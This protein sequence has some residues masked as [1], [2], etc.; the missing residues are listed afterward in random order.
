VRKY[1]MLIAALVVSLPA[2]VQAAETEQ[3]SALVR[4]ITGR[5]RAA[6]RLPFS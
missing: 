6:I 3:P 2:L 5:N 1:V 4:A